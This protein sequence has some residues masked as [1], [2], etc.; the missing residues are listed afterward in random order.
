ME[1]SDA[2][3]E[4]ILQ[5]RASL[6]D[7]GGR[8]L[9][10]EALA[11]AA[12]E[13]PFLRLAVWAADGVTAMQEML[14]AKKVAIFLLDAQ[15]APIE[16]RQEFSDRMG[17]DPEYAERITETI[18]ET[19]TRIDRAHKVPLLASAFRA[20]LRGDISPAMFDR[21]GEIVARLTGDGL[22]ALEGWFGSS[23][24]RPI[25]SSGKRELLN[26]GLLDEYVT[27]RAWSLVRSALDQDYFTF[28]AKRDPGNRRLGTTE[29]GAQLARALGFGC[30]AT[31]T[32]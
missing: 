8:A 20:M 32:A 29:V 27:D 28:G 23:E 22:V 19:L 15:Q 30:P 26:L 25:S 16:E 21:C 3:R 5:D 1:A 12:E 10:R 14:L 11:R 2:L 31:S 9:G 13:V 17:R 24:W 4:S 18:V 7:R 6:T